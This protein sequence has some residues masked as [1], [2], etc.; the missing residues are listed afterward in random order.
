MCVF[1]FSQPNTQRTHDVRRAFN[2]MP[3]V[4]I[5]RCGANSDQEL[6]V[7]WRWFFNVL[8]FE[9]SYTI[10]TIDD[11]LHRTRR[12]SGAITD[13]RRSPVGDE[14]HQECEQQQH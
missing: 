5:D 3:V 12:S 6:I 11:G 9:V 4:R 13:V 8:K 1:W 2:E 10:V 14:P 7:S